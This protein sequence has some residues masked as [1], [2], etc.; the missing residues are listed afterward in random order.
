MSWK[1]PEASDVPSNSAP[2]SR[3]S[4]KR[5]RAAEVHNMSEKVCAL[6]TPKFDFF[7]FNSHLAL[8]KFFVCVDWRTE[9]EE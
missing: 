7:Y 4:S 3:N 8:M 1:G 6:K 2:P 5:S 9:E